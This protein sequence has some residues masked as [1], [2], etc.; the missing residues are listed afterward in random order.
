MWRI[1]VLIASAAIGASTITAPAP[2]CTSN[3][4]IAGTS[5][6]H[7]AFAAN[8]HN[9][10]QIFGL[11]TEPVTQG[12]LLDKWLRIEADIT[13][14]LKIIA[15]CQASK[16]CP[17]PA[18]M[19]MELSLEGVNR[20]WRARVGLINRAVDLAISPM[21]D[22]TQWGVAD[23]WSDPFE[24]LHSTLGDCEDY[25]IV[26]YAALRA[27][28]FPKTSV[29]LIVLRNRF[30]NE[31]HAVAAVW[32]DNQWLILDNRTLTLVRDTD[33]TRAIPKFVLDEE[34]VRRFVWSN[35]KRNAASWFASSNLDGQAACPRRKLNLA[36][37]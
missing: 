26:K 25:A 36:G 30:P 35:P 27:A 23:H 7:D 24:T 4:E 13:K 10:D 1:T 16:P 28:G 33:V 20:S 37:N 14:E 15:Q 6:S 12:R 17:A 31:D 8:D 9:P 29:R 32:V 2:V 18:Q 3:K 19:L 21:S 11:D 22:E 5:G 34:G